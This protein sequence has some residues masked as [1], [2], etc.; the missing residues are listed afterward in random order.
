MTTGPTL[1]RQVPY[2]APLDEPALAAL[3]R[4]VRR[5]TYERGAAIV[6]EGERSPELFFVIEGRVKVVKTSPEGREQVLLVLGP[7]RS[8][9]DVPI[10]DGGPNPGT[11]LALEPCVVGAVPAAVVLDLVRRHPEVAL[12]A[13][14]VLASRVRA[15]A[16]RIEDL[17]FR[18]VV[19]RVARLLVDCATDRATLIEGQGGTC[20]RL[21]QH[22]IA[23]MTGTVREVV[24]RALKTLERH[25]AIVMERAHVSVRDLDVLRQWSDAA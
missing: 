5:R 15:F 14:R 22:D 13:T 2:F 11:V 9:N 23:A 8:F 24:Q 18:S 20:R 7:G 17:A 3:A 4:Q 21:T 6:L 16:A 19:G 12:A 1:V 10:F 25:G